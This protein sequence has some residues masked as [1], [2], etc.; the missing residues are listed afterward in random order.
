MGHF[1]TT[2]VP[3]PDGQDL[4]DW[5]DEHLF[6]LTGTGRETGAAGYFVKVI[7]STDPDLI[8]KDW[9][10]VRMSSRK[11]YRH[12]AR[13]IADIT[14]EKIRHFVAIEFADLFGWDNPHFDR[15]VFLKACCVDE[16]PSPYLVLAEEM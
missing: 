11:D 4:D 8:G 7:E 6:P 3:A 14:D 15:E 2:T 1:E 9:E 10:W 13:I 5:A 12:A 16:S